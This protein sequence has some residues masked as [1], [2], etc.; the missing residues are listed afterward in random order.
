M[1]LHNTTTTDEFKQKVISSPKVVLV[2]FWAQWCPPC[3]AMT[4]VLQDVA[5][6]LDEIADVVKV[7][8][9]ESS[10]NN[11]LAG[12]HQVQSIPNMLI[13]KDGQEVGRLIGMTPKAALIDE[14]K[15][16]TN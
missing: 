11:R 13:F 6:E 3:L 12:D 1:A 14:L 9:E 15:K 8:I 16:Y 7:N 10:D 2:D 4:P 5:K